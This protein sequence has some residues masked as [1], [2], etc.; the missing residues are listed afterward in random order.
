MFRSPAVTEDGTIF[1]K[2]GLITGG[3][4]AST[5]ARR[6]DEGTVAGTCLMCFRSADNFDLNF[7]VPRMQVLNGFRRTFAH[8]SSNWPRPSRA[9][10]RTNACWPRSLV[11]RPI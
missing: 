2:A 4:A 3:A 8:N 9:T 5:G 7:V 1:H 10:A 11:W 6:W